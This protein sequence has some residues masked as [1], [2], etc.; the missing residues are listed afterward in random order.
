MRPYINGLTYL[1]A[2]V[3]LT[4]L[5]TGAPFRYP[6]GVATPGTLWPLKC[7]SLKSV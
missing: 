3:R 4:S 7:R 6:L 2:A 1:R 5:S